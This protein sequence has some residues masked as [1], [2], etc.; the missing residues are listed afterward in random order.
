MGRT[1]LHSTGCL[2]DFE[3]KQNENDEKDEAESAAAIVTKPWS[4]T[5][6][7]EAEHKNQNDQKDKH[8]LS[9]YG[10]ISPDEGVMR[11]LLQTH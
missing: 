8:C 3:Q 11:I 4:H 10:E 2:D 5:I 6:P 7:A 1:I 9:P